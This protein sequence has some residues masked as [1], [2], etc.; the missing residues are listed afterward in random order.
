MWILTMMAAVWPTQIWRE[1]VWEGNFSHN[2]LSDSIS[3][4][5][6]TEIVNHLKMFAISHIS[7]TCTFFYI[8]LQIHLIKI[9]IF[10]QMRTILEGT[11]R[12]IYRMRAAAP[13][14]NI[15]WL[16][17]WKA[18]RHCGTS[19]LSVRAT[20]IRRQQQKEQSSQCHMMN[21]LWR[22]TLQ[23]SRRVKSSVVCCLWCCSHGVHHPSVLISV[24]I[25]QV[26]TANSFLSLGHLCWSILDS[27]HWS[28]RLFPLRVLDI[29][30]PLCLELMTW[31][32]ETYVLK[33]SPLHLPLCFI[34]HRTCWHL[35]YATAGAL[36]CN[37]THIYCT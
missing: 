5:D 2:L 37:I 27:C 7:L 33:A 23:K 24:W 3:Q 22:Q 35:R 18:R 25:S 17:A 31:K 8:K 29:Y 4:F 6:K 19:Q 30:F 34:C 26:H 12:L 36:Y 15:H 21:T 14:L 9:M 20:T 1:I 32:M 10:P 11:L 13:G 28:Q 16:R